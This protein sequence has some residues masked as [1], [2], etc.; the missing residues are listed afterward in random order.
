MESP[1]PL[2]AS[3]ATSAMHQRPIT[4]REDAMAMELCEIIDDAITA[5][6]LNLGN[7]VSFERL[8][9]RVQLIELAGD[10]VAAAAK[11]AED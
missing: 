5:D 4:P 10:A 11:A 7:L 3:D 8:L 2:G 9:R 6:Q 1:E